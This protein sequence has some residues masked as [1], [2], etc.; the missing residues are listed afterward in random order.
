MVFIPQQLS[1]E[2]ER[3][4]FLHDDEVPLKKKE[5]GKGGGEKKEGKGGRT[6]V[7]HTRKILEIL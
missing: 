5:G 3:K 4:V 2:T 1:K 7:D 6:V